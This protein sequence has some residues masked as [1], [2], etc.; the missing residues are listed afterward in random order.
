MARASRTYCEW[1]CVH[2]PGGIDIRFRIRTSSHL[3]VYFVVYVLHVRPRVC[4]KSSSVLAILTF[5]LEH[6]FDF[7]P[8]I[9][10]LLSRE[11]RANFS[12]CLSKGSIAKSTY[13]N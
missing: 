13:L 11:V 7:V 2:Q 10:L 1:F 6:A 9:P 5:I 3:L 12:Q 8:R 4:R